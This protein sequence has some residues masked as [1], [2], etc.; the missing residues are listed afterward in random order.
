M[1]PEEILLVNPNTGTSPLFRSRRDAEITV[2]IY[3]R[4]PVLCRDS[5]PEP[6]GAVIPRHVPSGQ[7]LRGLP[8]PGQLRGDGSSLV[9]NVFVRDDKRMLP[10]YEAKM[11]HHFDHRLGTYEGQTEAQ[12]NMGTLPRSAPGQKDDPN[13]VVLPRYWVAGDAVTD[14]LR[15]RWDQGW[16]LGWRDTARSTDER[17][18]IAAAIHVGL[19]VTSIYSYFRNP[20]AHCSRPTCQPLYSTILCAKKSLGQTSNILHLSSSLPFRLRPTQRQL[21]GSAAQ[22]WARGSPPAS[23]SWS[24]R[25]TICARSLGISAMTGR[26]FTGMNSAGDL[27]RA[28]L[29]AAYFRLYGVDRDD[30]DYIMDTFSTVKRRDEA[31]DG[32]YRTKRMIL[33]AYDAMPTTATSGVPYRSPLRPPPGDGPR[34]C[35]E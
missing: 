15:G 19:S 33:E 24:T 11:V 1:P 3:R 34:H 25:A 4:V 21:P 2:G 29:D 13:Y 5:P 31:A 30:V 16:L 22:A 23:S 20:H 14:R 8:H 6:V 27:I 7:R 26:H 9:G 28:E 17:T 12:A 18:L 35:S 32:E 10:L